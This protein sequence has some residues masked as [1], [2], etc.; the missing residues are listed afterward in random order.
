[1]GI[2]SLAKLLSDE[3]PDVSQETETRANEV[4]PG[5]DALQQGRASMNKE[6]GR[7]TASCR[8]AFVAPNPFDSHVDVYS[9][10]V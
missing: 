9:S 7:A 6:L 4:L 2:K 10:Y 5:L 3:A 1:M 8:S